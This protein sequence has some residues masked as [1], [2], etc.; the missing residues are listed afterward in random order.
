MY[1]GI[2]YTKINPTDLDRTLY[3]SIY[4]PSSFVLNDKHRCREQRQRAT[5]VIQQRR[6]KSLQTQLKPPNIYA[7]RYIPVCTTSRGRKSYTG[8]NRERE[9]DTPSHERCRCPLMQSVAMLCALFRS[10]LNSSPKSVM[11]EIVACGAKIVGRVKRGK[12]RVTDRSIFFF[13]FF[14]YNITYTANNLINEKSIIL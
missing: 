12:S 4:K 11:V 8:N 10:V 14:I 6:K 2:R 3:E 13:F 1:N 5:T 7:H 9:G